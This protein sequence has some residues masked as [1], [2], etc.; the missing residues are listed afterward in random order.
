MKKL[1]WM[2]TCIF[3]PWV[4]IAIADEFQKVR[5]GSDI[6]KALIGQRSSNER[7][8]VTERKYRALGLKDPRR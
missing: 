1:S 4:Q 7:V 8:V 5:C 2:L 6:P 3:L